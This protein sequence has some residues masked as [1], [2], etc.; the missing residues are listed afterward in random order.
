MFETLSPPL[1]PVLMK[2]LLWAGNSTSTLDALEVLE[3]LDALE[4][5]DPLLVLEIA[6]TPE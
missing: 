6:D 3:A 4:P 2:V 1:F 5:L